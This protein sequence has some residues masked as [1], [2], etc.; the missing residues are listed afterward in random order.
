MTAR[1]LSALT[2]ARNAVPFQDKWPQHWR[3]PAPRSHYDAV[4]VVG[5][6]MVWRRRTTWRSSSHDHVVVLEKRWPGGGNAGRNTC[7]IRSNYFHPASARFYD[8]SFCLRRSV[9]RA[10]L[11]HHAEPARAHQPRARSH[12]VELLHRWATRCGYRG[13]WRAPQRR[14]DPQVVVAAR[15]VRAR[16][17]PVRG[18]FMQRG[19]GI[20][21]HAR[22]PGA[23]RAPPMLWAWTS[24][25]T[26]R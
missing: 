15:C 8:L 6:G 4:I 13:G 10:G 26:A 19:A 24:F 20:A 5:E 9:A 14:T 11:Q 2:L 18:G 23:M 16:G 21:G 12:E 22:S 17:Y 3:S 1:R 25:R 7:V